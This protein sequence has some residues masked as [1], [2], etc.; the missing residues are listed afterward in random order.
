NFLSGGLFTLFSMNL[1][2]RLADMYG[3]LRLFAI[4]AT[5]SAGAVLWLTHLTVEPLLVAI[6][7]TTV[8]MVT[9]TGRFVP[10]IAMITGSAEA[11]HR[12]GFMSL[13]S[14]VQQVFSG[15]GTS[16]G[17]WLII[18]QA[19]Q[20]LRNYGLIGCIAAGIAVASIGLAYRLRRP[21]AVPPGHEP[22]LAEAV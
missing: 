15:L 5:L 10:A 4:M 9:M 6:G 1:V 14:C 16:L 18:D 19:H 8:F 3:R 7:V 2:G 13:N 20:P 11:R 22:M 21:V 12:G 17:G